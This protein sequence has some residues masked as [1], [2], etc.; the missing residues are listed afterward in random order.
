MRQTRV[1][2][3][4]YADVETATFLKNYDQIKTRTIQGGNLLGL[5]PEVYS[6]TTKTRF[7]FYTT[8]GIRCSWQGSNPTFRS[9]SSSPIK[10]VELVNHL[11]IG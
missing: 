1:H 10:L 6:T 7:I 4:S 3:D 5:R 9:F 11:L 8:E 2:G